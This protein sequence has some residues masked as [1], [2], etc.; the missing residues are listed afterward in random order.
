MTVGAA[1]THLRSTLSLLMTASG[2]QNR[3]GMIAPFAQSGSDTWAPSGAAF[4]GSVL[5]VGALQSRTLL[6]MD[7]QTSR[8]REI[9]SSGDR[10]RDVLVRRD[11][12]YVVTTNRSPRREGPSQDRL[13]RLTRRS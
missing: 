13:F 11:A 1:M 9:F 7:T 5:L 6:A 4:S 12:I 10:L 3:E 2:S 8:V